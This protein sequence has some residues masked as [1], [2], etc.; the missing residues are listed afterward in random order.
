MPSPAPA[1]AVSAAVAPP[2]DTSPTTP[3]T[4][5]VFDRQT[6]VLDTDLLFDPDDVTNLIAAARTIQHLV[7]VTADEVGGWRARAARG[8]LDAIGRTDV[9][10]IEGVDLGNDQ[11]ILDPQTR[12]ELPQPPKIDLVDGIRDICD[13]TSEQVIWV[14]C[15]PMTNLAEIL[16]ST[17]DLAEQ[18]L[19]TQMGGWLDPTRYR[20][21]D[22]AS[23]NLR[24]DERSAGVALRMCHHLRLVLSEHTGVPQTRITRDSLLYRRFA[25]PDAPAWATMAA[26]NFDGWFT[27]RTG[28]WMHDPLTLAAILQMPFITFGEERIRIERDVRLYRDPQGRTIRVSDTV[29]YPAFMNWLTDTVC[30]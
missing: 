17:P 1:C 27:H 19:V 2:P 22:K 24:I 4:G 6:V 5:A 20:N 26:A 28:S 7:V 16:E 15:G 25:A 13:N 29:D 30:P 10:V 21:P 18:L 12:D 11:L 9:P 23:H 8:V 3:P 14:G